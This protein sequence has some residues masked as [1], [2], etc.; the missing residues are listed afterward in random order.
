[1]HTDRKII[2][3][4]GVSRG[5]GLA[6]AEGFVER[7]HLICGSARDKKSVAALAKR[8]PE[9]HRFAAVDVSDDEQ[10]RAWADGV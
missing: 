4:T 8:W 6:M 1:M 3:L 7:G 2:V 5:L 10:V 9:S